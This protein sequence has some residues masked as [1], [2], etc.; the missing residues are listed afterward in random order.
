MVPA[1]PICTCLAALLLI[2]PA[3]AHP[4]GLD[5]AGCHTNRKTGGYHC[6]GGRSA[7]S[8]SPKGP[9]SPSSSPSSRARRMPLSGSGYYPN[10]AA[11]RAA[12]AAPL[13]RGSPGY[14]AG[15]DRDGDGVACE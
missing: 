10:C 15:L 11:V 6:H 14:R 7:A 8:S 9:S 4:G 2:A 13:R 5:A 12:G 3:A 1:L